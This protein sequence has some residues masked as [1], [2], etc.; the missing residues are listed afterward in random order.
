MINAVVFTG[1][2][3]ISK[4][5]MLFWECVHYRSMSWN[6]SKIM[7]A[8]ENNSGHERLFLT[9]SQGRP[10]FQRSFEWVPKWEFPALWCVFILR[11]NAFMTDSLPLLSKLL[12]SSSGLKFYSQGW[13][14]VRGNLPVSVSWILG[15]KVCPNTLRSDIFIKISEIW[16]SHKIWFLCFYI[17]F[18][19]VFLSDTNLLSS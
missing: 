13:P 16:F 7:N 2:L 4:T 6:N 9:P 8:I 15:L 11:S 17:V 5:V 10:E 12:Y 19:E 18:Y 14:Q 1:L 3:S